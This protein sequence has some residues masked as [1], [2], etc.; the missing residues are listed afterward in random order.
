MF[1]QRPYLAARLFGAAVLWSL[2]V[3]SAKAQERPLTFRV[4]GPSQKLEMV[5]NS[6]RILEMDYEVPRLLVENPGVLKANPLSP[7]QVQLAALKSRGS[8]TFRCGTTT[9]KCT[10]ST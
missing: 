5:V 1:Q 8:P 2:T 9:A 4:S 10:R 7:K 3:A 6:S